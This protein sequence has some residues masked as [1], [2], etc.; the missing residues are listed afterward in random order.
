MFYR[1]A[2]WTEVGIHGTKEIKFEMT[3]NDWITNPN[4]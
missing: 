1:K 2:G 4:F 3:Y